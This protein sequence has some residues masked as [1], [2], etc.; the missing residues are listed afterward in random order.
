MRLSV[1]IGEVSYMDEKIGQSNGEAFILSG[2]G[3][4]NLTKT[5]RLSVQTFSDSINSELKV[6][7]A[8]IDDIVSNWTHLHG[9]IMYQSLLTDSTQCELAKKLGTS[10]QNICKTST[11]CQ[12]KIS[13]IIFK[14]ILFFDY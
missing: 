12:R 11:L 14:S 7:T 2:H 8:F 6:E 9:E 3:F 13:K 5:Q 1:G 4:D 10:Q